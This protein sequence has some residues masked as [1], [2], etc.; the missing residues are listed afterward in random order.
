MFNTTVLELLLHDPLIVLLTWLP[1]VTAGNWSRTA[2]H[3]GP[4][5]RL[6]LVFPALELPPER[7]GSSVG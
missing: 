1:L 3:D 6:H 7:G 4:G 2:R 5:T